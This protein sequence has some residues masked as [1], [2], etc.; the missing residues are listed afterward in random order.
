MP[1]IPDVKPIPIVPDIKPTPVIPD[2]QGVKNI[3]DASKCTSIQTF[4][5]TLDY[6]MQ[7][8][9]SIKSIILCE[10]TMPQ[11]VTCSEYGTNQFYCYVTPPDISKR[12]ELFYFVKINGVNQLD[13]DNK[14]TG[15]YNNVKYSYYLYEPKIKK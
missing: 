12:F 5:G 2:G 8:N 4:N 13:P 1:V 10:G 15:M 7:G 11:D 3:F 9:P 14:N 6:T